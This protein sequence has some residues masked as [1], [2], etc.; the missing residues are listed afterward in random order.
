MAVDT[1]PSRKSWYNS[2]KMLGKSFCKI[3]T[4]PG[5]SDFLKHWEL[6]LSWKLILNPPQRGRQGVTS[7]P[8][9]A[10]GVRDREKWVHQHQLFSWSENNSFLFSPWNVFKLWPLMFQ[11][12]N[13]QN[14]KVLNPLPKVSIWGPRGE[15]SAS[16]ERQR[17]RRSSRR[18]PIRCCSRPPSDGAGNS[19]PSRPQLCPFPGLSNH[20]KNKILLGVAHRTPKVFL[21]QVWILTLP[22]GWRND[23][24]CQWRSS[25]FW[26]G[27]LVWEEI[28]SLSKT[29]KL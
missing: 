2:P 5:I 6:P 14:W 9:N 24:G 1:L 22:V 28:G 8:F 18:L 15:V 26:I 21:F 7:A 25:L 13:R 3:L 11:N 10:A 27:Q 20:F 12:H 17:T 16:R 19:Q 29:T 4:W 23:T